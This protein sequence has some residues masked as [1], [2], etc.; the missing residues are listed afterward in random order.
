M[1]TNRKFDV[2]FVN[3]M[4]SLDRSVV[5][6]REAKWDAL[7]QDFLIEF[8]EKNQEDALRKITFSG[9]FST[10]CHEKDKICHWRILDVIRVVTIIVAA[11]VVYWTLRLL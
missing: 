10:L 2:G 11:L 1:W 9:I 3:M 4:K 7:E 6:E 5:S 8:E